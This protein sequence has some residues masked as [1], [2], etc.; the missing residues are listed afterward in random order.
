MKK[1]KVLRKVAVVLAVFCLMILFTGCEPRQE[2]VVVEE[3]SWEYIIK[4]EKEVLCQESAWSLPEDATLL[5]E[6][7]EVYKE[8][9]DDEGKV[10]GYEYRTKYYYE[11]MRW[12]YERSVITNGTGFFEYFGEYTLAENERVDSQQK[13]YYIHGKNQD[14]KT[15]KYE[16][17]RKEWREIDEGDTLE[18]EISFFG[19]VNILSHK[20][21]NT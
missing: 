13:N 7:Q 2:T 20:K 12:K 1:N 5:E 6:K 8:K 18:L 15:V 19:A 14:G 10:I 16:V 11:I 4:I 17:P 3:T 21:V 9:L